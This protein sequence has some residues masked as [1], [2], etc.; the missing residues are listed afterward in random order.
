MRI[1]RQLLAVVALGG[2]AAAALARPPQADGAADGAKSRAQVHAEAVAATAGGQVSR[3]ESAA[4][5]LGPLRSAHSRAEVHAEA[6]AAVAGGQSSSNER[7]YGPSQPF[8]ST[9]TRAEVRAEAIEARRLGLVSH[10]ELF[11]RDAT[12]A[13]LE[14]IR[15]AGLRAREADRRVAAGK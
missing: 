15:Q 13:E 9:R 2:F 10:G 11:P 1:N 3:G 5:D 12:P 14:L 6:V 4:S 7:D 8:V